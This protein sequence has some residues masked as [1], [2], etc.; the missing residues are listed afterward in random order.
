MPSIAEEC[1]SHAGTRSSPLLWSASPGPAITPPRWPTSPRPPGCP[2]GLRICTSPEEALFIALYEEWDC[3][4]AARIDAAAVDLP[5]PAAP[6]PRARSWPRWHR[7]SPLYVLDNPQTCRVLMEATTLAAYEPAIAAKVQ[8][9]KRRKPRSAHRPVPGR[10]RRRNGR[11]GHRPGVAWACPVHG[12]PVRADGPVAHRAGARSPWRAA[13]AVLAG[14]GGTR[15]Q[16]GTGA[17]QKRKEPTHERNHDHLRRTAGPRVGCRT[18]AGRRD[19]RAGYAEGGL[20]RAELDE[21]LTRPTSARTRA[22]LHGLTSDSRHR[23]GSAYT[24]WPRDALPVRGRGGSGRP[25]NGAYWYALLWSRSPRRD[26]L[27]DPGRPPPAA[28]HRAIPERSSLL[29]AETG[30]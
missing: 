13:M 1:A 10:D 3:G 19:V 29:G 6:V 14:A 7:P 15:P 21:R 26:R 5:E 30:Q 18:G 11:R 22:D 24:D 4:L 8:A 16:G 9:C 20:S 17:I 2:R 25:P 23:G 27:L 28:R 12:G